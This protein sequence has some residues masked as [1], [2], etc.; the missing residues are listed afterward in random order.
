MEITLVSQYSKRLEVI[1][2]MEVI[3]PI[4]LVGRGYAGPEKPQTA[5]RKPQTVVILSEAKNPSSI[6][7]RANNKRDSSLR[8]E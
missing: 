5:N 7:V 1:A 8:S 2:P 4:S 6:Y 3:S